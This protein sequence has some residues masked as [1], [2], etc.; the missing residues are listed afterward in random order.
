MKRIIEMGSAATEHFPT[1]I[2]YPLKGIPVSFFF[3]HIAHEWG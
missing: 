3:S 1:L 2:Q